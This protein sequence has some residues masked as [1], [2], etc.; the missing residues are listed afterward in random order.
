MF[1]TSEAGKLIC[2]EREGKGRQIKWFWRKDR[3]RRTRRRDFSSSFL[4]KKNSLEIPYRVSNRGGEGLRE[5]SADTV[6]VDSNN[7]SK[8]DEEDTAHRW[9]V[10]GEK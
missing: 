3:R 4:E 8:G 9:G 5:T 7:E 2:F 10:G 1:S 6:S